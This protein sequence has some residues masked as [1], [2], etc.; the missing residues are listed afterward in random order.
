MTAAVHPVIVSMMNNII[1]NSGMIIDQRSSHVIENWYRCRTRVSS[2][3]YKVFVRLNNRRKTQGIEDFISAEYP[4]YKSEQFLLK[5]SE[6][7]EWCNDQFGK[8]GY[9]RIGK[10]L[11]FKNS[12]DLMLYKLRW[13][14]E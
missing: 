4:T 12:K 10:E 8:N 9:F 7:T 14:N 13:E 3:I 2:A 6:C 11:I 1:Y 5:L